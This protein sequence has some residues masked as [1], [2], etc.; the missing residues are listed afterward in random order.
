MGSSAGVALL[1]SLTSFNAGGVHL[2]FTAFLTHMC[3]HTLESM[4]NPSSE[5]WLF[6]V[7]F[8]FIYILLFLLRNAVSC[9]HLNVC[10]LPELEP[11]CASVCQ[12]TT[13]LRLLPLCQVQSVKATVRERELKG[14]LNDYNAP[15]IRGHSSSID[16]HIL[17]VSH[18]QFLQMLSVVCDCSGSIRRGR[19]KRKQRDESLLRLF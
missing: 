19:N 7:F 18:R 11:E 2:H 10:F 3:K 13:A 8:I 15:G 16:S 17:L 5:F 4:S 12:A 14:E 1:C 9:I 6:S